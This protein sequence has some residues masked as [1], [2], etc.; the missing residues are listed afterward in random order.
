[1]HSDNFTGLI[2]LAG[3]WEGIRGKGVYHE[4]WKVTAKNEMK[5][6]AYLM[7]KGEITSNEILKLHEDSSGIHYTA[8]VSHNSEPVSFLLTYA[9]D[10]TF[11][12]ENPEHDFPTKITYVNNDN[13]S[14]TATVEAEIDNSLK[15]FEYFLNKIL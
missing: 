15:K 5:G 4:E 3:K 9:D 11:V 1:M 13:K 2:W 7:K 6:R 14:L 10:T 12:F 8:D